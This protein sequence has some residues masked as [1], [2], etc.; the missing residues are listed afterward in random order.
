MKLLRLVDMPKEYLIKFSISFL[1][2]MSVWFLLGYSFYLNEKINKV[3]YFITQ[4]QQSGT[5][6]LKEDIDLQDLISEKFLE[7]DKEIAKLQADIKNLENSH[8]KRK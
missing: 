8:E 7:Q 1:F 2:W 3:K 5:E 6:F 4:A